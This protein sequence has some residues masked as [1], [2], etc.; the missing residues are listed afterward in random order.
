MFLIISPHSHN[1]IAERSMKQRS[2]FSRVSRD[3]DDHNLVPPQAVLWLAYA[4][5]PA[6]SMFK[7]FFLSAKTPSHVI[8]FH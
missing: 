4:V 5:A 7:E 6:L 3:W 8:L 2:L 1:V